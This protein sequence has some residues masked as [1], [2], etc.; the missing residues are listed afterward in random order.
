VVETDPVTW[1]E[2]ATGRKSWREAVT[3]G[4]IQVSGVRADLSVYLPL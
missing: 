3:T 2:V 1:I 4:K